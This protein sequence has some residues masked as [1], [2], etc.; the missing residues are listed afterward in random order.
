M[1][2][3]DNYLQ[4]MYFISQCIKFVSK[5][6]HRSMKKKKQHTEVTEN[7]DT[8]QQTQNMAWILFSSSPPHSSHRSSNTLY[9]P[10]TVIFAM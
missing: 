4:V 8:G 3:N 5:R 6:Q 2:E 9:A 1:Q 10:E 7:Q